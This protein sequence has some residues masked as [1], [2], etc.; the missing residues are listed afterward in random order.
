MHFPTTM[1][2]RVLEMCRKAVSGVGLSTLLLEYRV[3]VKKLDQYIAVLEA[4]V[5]IGVV[6]SIAEDES[7]GKWGYKGRGAQ[8]AIAEPRTPWSWDS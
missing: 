7:L 4:D 1:I 6:L 2:S 3:V 8:A 5:K